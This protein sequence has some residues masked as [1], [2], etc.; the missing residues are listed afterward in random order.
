M[1]KILANPA[2]AANKLHYLPSCHSTNEVAR[3]LFQQARHTGQP[4][5]GLVVVTDEQT[6][7]KGQA[8]SRWLAAPG[9]NLTCSLLL[10]P[11]F[12][13]ARQQFLLTVM[14]SLAL[15]QALAKMGL[16]A[17]IKWP[18]DI[19][20]EE[21][22]L[23]GILIEN[24]LRGQALEGSIVGIG[25]NVN[26][27]VF[28]PE[29]R[30]V[31]MKMAA[32]REF[33]LNEVLSTLL[34]ETGRLYDELKAGRVAV[35]KDLYDKLLLGNGKNRVFED[36]NGKFSGVIIGTDTFG[37]LLVQRK[38]GLYKYQHKEITFLPQN[39]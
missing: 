18:N 8:G 20:H 15:R 22:K 32:G 30:A 19:W 3:Q 12:L 9:Q 14:V 24:I 11:S 5:D 29:I 10:Q 33:D 6:A 1:Y 37:R 36:A 34:A 25:L 7:G 31:S 13:P 28:P 26:Q 21:H 23:A 27:T 38:E 4:L 39:S 16:P 17:D 35:M 2:F